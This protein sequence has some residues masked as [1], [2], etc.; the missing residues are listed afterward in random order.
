MKQ[1]ILIILNK[2]SFLLLSLI[3]FVTSQAQ[4]DDALIQID[5]Q[6]VSVIPV[7]Y[8]LEEG[9]K[10]NLRIIKLKKTLEPNAKINKLDSIFEKDS[11]E[12]YT[13]RDSLL[14]QLENVTARSLKIHKVEWIFYHT[15]L[16]RYQNTSQKILVWQFCLSHMI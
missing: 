10:I 7:N 16:K 11:V 4:N 3:F 13:K 2:Y 6:A 5:T 15:Y 9:E 1:T 14:N 8:I 12:I